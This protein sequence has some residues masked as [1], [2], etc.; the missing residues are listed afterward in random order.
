MLFK[1]KFSVKSPVIGTVMDQ[2]QL[3]D[4]CFANSLLGETRALTPEDNV[5]CSPINGKLTMI[6]DTSHAFGVADE[7][8]AEFLVH[9]GIDTVNLKGECFKVLAEAGATVKQGQPIIEFDREAAA[10]KGFNTSV[11]LVLLSSD[12]YGF[13]GKGKATKVTTSDEIETYAPKK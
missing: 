8:G 7:N 6:A 5:I 13:Q 1:K 2:T 4:P 11:I 9:I 3:P 10:E 12:A